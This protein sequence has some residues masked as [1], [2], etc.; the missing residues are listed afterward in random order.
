MANI[1]GNKFDTVKPDLRNNGTNSLLKKLTL[2]N[3]RN[4]MHSK[5]LNFFK[6]KCL[7]QFNY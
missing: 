3:S 2:K 6:Q 5:I 1:T 4:F 7:T